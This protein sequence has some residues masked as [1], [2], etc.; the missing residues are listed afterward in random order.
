MTRKMNLAV[1]LGLGLLVAVAME[2]IG[3]VSVIETALLAIAVLLAVPALVFA[4]EIALACWP[5]SKTP[6]VPERT[7]GP[8]LAVVVPAHN[9]ASGIE[10]T[11]SGLR[12]QLAPKDRL[13][14]VADNCSDETAAIARA[15]GAEVFERRDLE[16]RG[17][18]FALDAG[19]RHLA[20]T[21]APEVVII[22]DADCEVADGALARLARTCAATGRPT[23]AL[24]RMR[25]PQSP[26]DEP[27]RAGTLIS[28]FAWVVKTDVRPRGL[29]RIGL[30]CP[31]FGTGMAFPWPVIEKA[32]LATGH[33]TEDMQL[34]VDLTLAGRAPLF[35]PE[36]VVESTFAATHDAH[37]AQR[38][39]W[40]HG[41]IDTLLHGVPRLFMTALKRLDGASLAM[42][43]DLSVPPLALLVTNLAVLFAVSAAWGATGGSG[44][45]ALISGLA[46]ALVAFAVI[47]AWLRFG[48]DLLPGT[49]LLAAPWYALRKMPIYL[50]FLF[51]RQTQW[52]RSRRDGER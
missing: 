8:R 46:L 45:A 38:T 52:V 4:A 29:A 26:G 14:V 49:T 36:A 5:G 13:L 15:A 10:A 42:A 7:R 23:Q 33:I 37:E 32:P 16:K 12:R 44:M 27:A 2:T 28:L 24:Y 9:E 22:V 1:L 30:P 40:E 3:L 25:L 50:R 18:G 34:G 35:A 48:R 17:K 11:V 47:L 20:A 43:L 41:H 6:G 51:A 31:L 39:R 19:V 21:G